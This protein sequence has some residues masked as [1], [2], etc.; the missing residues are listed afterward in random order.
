MEDSDFCVKMQVFRFKDNIPTGKQISDSKKSIFLLL[1]FLLPFKLK[2]SLQ[3]EKVAN[4]VSII[5]HILIVLFQSRLCDSSE[6]E[7]IYRRPV[8]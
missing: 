4:L 3:Q 8:S 5:A 1:F 7:S 2:Y 6:L